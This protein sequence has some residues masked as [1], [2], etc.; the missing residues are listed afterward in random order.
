MRLIDLRDSDLSNLDTVLPRPELNISAAVSKVRPIMEQVHR[1]GV[2]ALREFSEHFD[3]IIPESFRVPARAIDESLASQSSEFISAL[4]VAIKNARVA[5]AAQIPEQ[6]ITEVVPGGY[7]YQRWVPLE[8]VGLY[9]P[10]GIAVYPS[11]VVMNVVAAQ[12]AGVP[13][14]VVASPP[15]RDNGGLPHPTILAACA[16]LGVDEVI[17]VGGAQAIAAL[18]YGFTEGDYRCDPVD[19][20][21]G[22]GNI[23]VAAAKR[24]AHEICGIDAEAG[25]TEIAILA[26]DSADP[27]YVA[28]DL[29]S[30]AEHD[31]AAASILV[32]PSSRLAEEVQRAL[33]PQ[34]EQAAHRER[35]G[36]ALS[37]PQSGIILTDD[38]E[39]ATQVIEKYG[40]EHLE[41]MTEDALGRSLSIKNAGAIFVGDFSPVPLGDY[42]AGSNH[43]LPTGGTSRYSSGLNST[44]FL[45]SVQVIDYDQAALCSVRGPLEV[46]AAA[47]GLSAHGTAAAIRGNPDGLDA[48]H[49]SVSLPFRE[50]LRSVHPYGAP[51]L[52]VPVR[53]N[54]NENPYTPTFGVI[55]AIADAV[56]T[57][58]EQLNRYAD[59]DAVEL[60]Q[61]LA[62]YIQ[63]E[64]GVPV[65]WEQIWAANGSNEVMLQLLQAF[66]GPGR[67]ALALGPTYSMYGEYARDTF[68]DFLM[69]D[70]NGTGFDASTLIKQMEEHRPS[71]VFVASPNNPTGTK[72]TNQELE[73][74]LEAAQTTGPIRR[75]ALRDQQG[76]RPE[77]S[78]NVRSTLVVV[79]EAYAEFRAHGEESAVELI[80]SYPH[81]VVTRTM[82]KAFA[83]AGLRLGYMISSS[84]IVDEVMKVRLPYH[85]SSL[86]Q[87][88]A[89]ATLGLAVEQIS[90]VDG[91]RHGRERLRVE[92]SQRGLTVVPSSANF[93]LFG[94]FDDR[95]SVWSGLLERGV[96][97]REVGPEGFLR[98]T[99]GTEDENDAFLRALD[100]V[101]KLDK[102]GAL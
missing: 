52:E 21:T 98:V 69:A 31:S 11:S 26:D 80:A 46:L 41:V 47:E 93:L 5:H 35:I 3:G 39:Q 92:L 89:A 65:K 99:V 96:L 8:R 1:D 58:A 24:I 81:L 12:A 83:A 20:V 71:V 33:I 14:L 88:A 57:A 50:D 38:I 44:A 22:P 67:G 82:S 59:R 95:H 84:R 28:A 27:Q 36:R 102:G 4:E 60:R 25:T 17:A 55:D 74:I 75:I 43:V 16:L 62:D 51:Q 73:L 64:S 9:V 68:T 87:A 54:V 29:I 72:V 94:T 86:T 61:D 63:E 2:Q 76:Q 101:M 100:E 77:R 30:Q 70:S 48:A 18:A 49:G 6:T 23:Y 91:L 56:R 79:D 90:T 97:I 10:G 66:G 85:L 78:T 53:L 45:R 42:V 32:T 40:P 13:G 15:Q 37:G 19:K 34:V 7:V